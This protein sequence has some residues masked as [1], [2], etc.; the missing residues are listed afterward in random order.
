MN[1]PFIKLV[2]LG[3]LATTSAKG[4]ILYSGP[5]NIEIPISFHG[6]YLTF[7]DLADPSNVSVDSSPP[8]PTDGSWDFNAFFGGAAIGTSDTLQ[9]VTTPNTAT[10]S[11]ITRLAW[12]DTVDAS[13][14]YPA[15]PPGYSGSTGH[16]GAGGS[17]WANGDQGYIGFRIDASRFGGTAGTY[18]YGWMDVTLHNDGSTGTIHGWAWEND[19]GVGVTIIPET[20]AAGISAV[21]LLS[22]AIFHRRR[23]R[24]PEAV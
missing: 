14:S 22:A 23:P 18:Y 6:V 19:L 7:N 24:R 9:P 15:T 10:N 12:N 11:A 17:Q 3:L 8:P 20:S 16:M 13:E 2:L 5:Q 21:L 4:A 1:R